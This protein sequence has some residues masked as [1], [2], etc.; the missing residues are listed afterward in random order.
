MC[1]RVDALLRDSTPRKETG[2]CV[3]PWRGGWCAHGE[4]WMPDSNLYTAEL[5]EFESFIFLHSNGDRL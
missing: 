5:I 1:Y 4:I 3:L 2:L